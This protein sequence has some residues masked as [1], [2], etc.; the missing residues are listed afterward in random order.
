MADVGPLERFLAGSRVDSAVFSLRPDY[1][2][3]LLAVDG[4]VPGRSDEASAALLRAAE[5]AAGDLL[6]DRPLEQLPHVAA[7]RDAYRTFGAK[8][9]RTRNSLE[10]LL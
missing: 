4:L 10:A 2:A 1:R 5:A 9:Q 7:W 6:C 8:P 3:L